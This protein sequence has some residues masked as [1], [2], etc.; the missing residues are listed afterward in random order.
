[1]VSRTREVTSAVASSL[2]RNE[3]AIA[4]GRP[5]ARHVALEQPAPTAARR[6]ASP[7]GSAR[8]DRKATPRSTSAPS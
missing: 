5:H 8:L 7:K 3:R 1:L 4:V 6:K 2:R